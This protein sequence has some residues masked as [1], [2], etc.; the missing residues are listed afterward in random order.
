[1]FI[2]VIAIT[3]LSFTRKKGNGQKGQKEHYSNKGFG[4]FHFMLI[5]DVN[6]NSTMSMSPEKRM[7]VKDGKA[8]CKVHFKSWSWHPI[9]Y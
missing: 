5:Y 6:K 2:A 7:A 8:F 9:L 4:C 1:M 3:Y